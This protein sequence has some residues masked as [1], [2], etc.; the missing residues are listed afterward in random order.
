MASGVKEMN[1]VVY[2]GTISGTTDDYG[3]LITGLEVTNAAVIEAFIVGQSYSVTPYRYT[4]SS[5]G[6]SVLNFIVTRSDATSY[7]RIPNTAVTIDYFYLK[8]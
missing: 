5:T 4:N 2:H 3:R 1:G 7:T 6:I 8:K